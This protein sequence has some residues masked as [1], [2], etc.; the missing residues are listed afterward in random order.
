M[1]PYYNKGNI[2]L[3][4]NDILR[5]KGKSESINL[6]I[7]SPPY[8]VGKEYGSSSDVG[9]YDDYLKWTEAWLAKAYQWLA[10]DGRLCLN[11]P[12]DANHRAED[13]TTVCSPTAVD[14]VHIA[15]T[16]GYRYRTTIVW[17]KG[18]GTAKGRTA[19]GSWMSASAPY[20]I[21]PVELI[22]VLYKD[23]WKRSRVGKSTI[24]KDEFME[25]VF[26]LWTFHA[27]S[28]TRLGH[29][30]PF[31]L[32][33]PKRCI[34]LFSYVDDTVLDP[35]AGSGSTLVAAHKDKRKAIGIELDTDYCALAVKRL[36]RSVKASR[37][38]F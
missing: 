29:P 35:F 25:W 18:L 30:A 8:N 33:L 32:E 11:I 14:I 27:A 23:D 36:R 31:P 7:T 10:V 21:A 37:K 19:W 6:I 3:Y 26:G 34:R 28:A 4:N 24:S 5:V 38:L 20:V 22:V 2:K 1:K 16:L 12:L 15:Q 9:S 13:D 17:S